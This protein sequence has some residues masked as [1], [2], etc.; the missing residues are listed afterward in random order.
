MSDDQ[1]EMQKGLM[2]AILQLGH[3]RGCSSSEVMAA[4][5]NI[6][7]SLAVQSNGSREGL[8]EFIEATLELQERNIKEA[9]SR[10]SAGLPMPDSA[11]V[12]PALRPHGTRRG[13]DA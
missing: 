13:G 7:T 3:E 8:M 6:V 2:A 9:L 4:C 5:L 1:T 12:V 11:V 10:A